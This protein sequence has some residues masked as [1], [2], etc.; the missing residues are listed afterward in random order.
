MPLTP[1]THM[2]IWFDCMCDR[3][4][5][6]QSCVTKLYSKGKKAEQA[7]SL[8]QRDLLMNETSHKHT[9]HKFV[10]YLSL[11]VKPSFDKIGI[12]LVV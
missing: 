10:N 4:C 1:T 6:T 8:E 12:T 11:N 5:T 3:M 9:L 2:L 7:N